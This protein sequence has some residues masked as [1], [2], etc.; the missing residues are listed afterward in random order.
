MKQIAL[1]GCGV[2]GRRHIRGFQQLLNAGQQ[3]F[4]LVA[5]C[6]LH[7][8]NAILAAELARD[9]L[10]TELPRF[11]SVTEAHSAFPDLEALIITTAPDTHAAIGIDAME[12]GL[13]VLV[14]KPIALTVSQ[15]I[16]LVRAAERTG[17]VLAVAENYRRDPI[18]RL[19]KALIDSGVLGSIYLI[20]QS[21][22]GSGERVIITPWR[23]RRQSGGIVVDM[24]I[25]YAD[26]FEYF[27]GPVESIFGMNGIVDQQRID[28]EGVRH[29]VDAEDLS[30]GVA[31]FASG[32]VGN[33][34]IDLGGRGDSHFTRV[35]HGTGGSLV[36]P[37]DRTGKPLRLVLRRDGVDE[38]VDGDELLS[39]VPEF[40]LDE[41]TAALFGGDRITTYDLP[42]ADIDA[43][44]LAI[45]QADFADAVA[46]GRAPEVD[47]VFGLRSLAIAYGLLESERLGRPAV[48]SELIRN[49][50]TPYQTE[51]DTALANT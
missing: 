23:H 44:L 27:L 47:G 43:N 24:G 9:L 15:G 18:N 49:E 46:Y 41:V 17:R 28:V 30:V 26:L 29:E 5:V 50:D 37:Q 10:S 7:E 16:S 33:L 1:V 42:F 31:R 3:R 35:V 13:H 40:R 36:I 38:K 25:H 32:A 39:L 48:V 22:S 8:P 4:D 2:M 14:E 12:R 21:S 6:D 19:A 11:S 20:V 45:E 34:L 51:I